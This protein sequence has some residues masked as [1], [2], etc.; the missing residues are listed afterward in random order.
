MLNT[1]IKSAAFTAATLIVKD[2]YPQVKKTCL[3]LYSSV[4]DLFDFTPTKLKSDTTITV[5][6]KQPRN[7]LTEYQYAVIMRAYDLN[8]T[9]PKNEKVNQQELC[10]RLNV[11]LG[12]NY[13]RSGY[14][15]YFRKRIIPEFNNGHK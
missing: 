12:L 11:D 8:S 5:K 7:Q 6:P 15:H 10:D 1:V 13:T 4:C 9:L 3:E 14:C 2:S